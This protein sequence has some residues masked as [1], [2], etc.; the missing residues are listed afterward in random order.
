MAYPLLTEHQVEERSG[1]VDVHTRTGAATMESI[2]IINSVTEPD[3]DMNRRRDREAVGRVRRLIG[4]LLGYPQGL[5]AMG[6]PK[7]SI[8]RE[9]QQ[10]S[11]SYE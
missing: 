1:G 11:P 5:Y 4:T 10:Y 6:T 2:R 3:M 9:Q 8:D 7:R